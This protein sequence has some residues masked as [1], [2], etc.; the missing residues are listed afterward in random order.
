MKSKIILIA[1]CLMFVLAGCRENDESFAEST[2]DFME[3]EDESIEA[4]D[5]SQGILRKE[6]FALVS[7]A[8]NSMTDYTGQYA[9]IEDMDGTLVLF[10]PYLTEYQMSVWYCWKNGYRV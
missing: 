6:V 5:I 4:A 7:S 9:Y 2:E 10:P 8:E 3:S 1:L